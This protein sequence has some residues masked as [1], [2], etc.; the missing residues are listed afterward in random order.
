VALETVDGAIPMH[1]APQLGDEEAGVALVLGNEVSGVDAAVLALSDAVLV[2]PVFGVKN[3]LNVACCAAI[4]LYE[5]LRRWGKYPSA[6][7]AP[8][9]DAAE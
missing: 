5:V 3:S 7:A 2:V 8:F 9:E 6:D 1:T 4:A